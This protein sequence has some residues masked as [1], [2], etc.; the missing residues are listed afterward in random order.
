[1]ETQTQYD[2]NRSVQL[3]RE[4]LSRSASVRPD[5]IAEL[6][7]H[8]RD[9]LAGLQTKGLTEE[10]AFIIATKRLGQPVELGAEFGKVNLKEV[11]FDRLVWVVAGSIALDI[12]YT[13]LRAVPQIFESVSTG[14]MTWF[15]AGGLSGDDFVSWCCWILGLAMTLGGWFLLVR[16]LITKNPSIN[17]P[18]LSPVRLFVYL[19]LSDTALAIFTTVISGI[20]EG[21]GYPLLAVYSESSFDLIYAGVM[22]ILVPLCIV[23]A[24]QACFRERSVGRPA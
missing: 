6:E 2:L 10:E 9:S 8:L 21:F 23:L 20:A 19:G 7:T 1:M 22:P 5:D 14:V 16:K 18:G 4:E 11:W 17:R 3:W 15:G 13:S 24:W 12:V